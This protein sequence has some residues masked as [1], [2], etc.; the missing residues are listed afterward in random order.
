MRFCPLNGIWGG[1]GAGIHQIDRVVVE[2][3][4]LTSETREGELRAELVPLGRN[5]RPRTT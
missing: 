4:K 3:M 1:G 2:V 5:N